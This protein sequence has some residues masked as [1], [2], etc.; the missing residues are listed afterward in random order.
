MW[1][2]L[3]SLLLLDLRVRACLRQ[4][5]FA[6]ALSAFAATKLPT[7][8]PKSTDLAA[9]LAAALWLRR[10]ANLSNRMPMFARWL[11]AVVGPSACL[12]QS[13]TL[14][15]YL[16]ARGLPAELKIGTRRGPG[17]GFA[18]HAWVELAGIALGE[19]GES[20]GQHVIFA[21]KL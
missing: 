11:N 19:P 21:A 17:S 15:A 14:R 6:A 8:H 5:G 9:A 2:N 16:V 4:S 7:R 13:I 18:A 20:S 3:P 10:F 1:L 12:D